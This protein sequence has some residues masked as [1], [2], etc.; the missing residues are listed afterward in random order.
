MTEDNNLY[1]QSKVA[2]TRTSSFVAYNATQHRYW[3]YRSSSASDQVFFETSSDRVTW[4]TRRTV[5][6]QFSITALRVELSAGT[7]AAQ[8]TPGTAIFDNFRIER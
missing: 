6:R 5:T 1:F 7:F 4:T 3:R 2:G 8:N